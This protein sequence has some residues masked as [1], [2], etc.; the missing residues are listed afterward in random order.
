MRNGAFFN[1]MILLEKQAYPAQSL[2]DKQWY[3]CNC[4]GENTYVDVAKGI[5]ALEQGTSIWLL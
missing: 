3:H 1:A 2:P 4:C 5:A